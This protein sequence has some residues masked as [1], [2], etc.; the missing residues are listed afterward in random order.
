MRERAGER[1]GPRVQCFVKSGVWVDVFV[2]VGVEEQWVW[3][4]PRGLREAMGRMR[5]G[6]TGKNK[7]PLMGTG[8]R[9]HGGLTEG[10]PC[11]GG[12]GTVCA[13]T[14]AQV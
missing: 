10:W 12:S 14:C 6:E 11:S 5:R 4:L 9:N 3:G 8:R 1:L 7:S 2:Q 13:C